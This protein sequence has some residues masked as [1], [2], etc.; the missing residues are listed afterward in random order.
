MRFV[1]RRLFAPATV[2]VAGLGVWL[3]FDGR[4]WHFRHVWSELAIGLFAGVLV[5]GAG[6]QRRAA[7]DAECAIAD[8][9]P[10]RARRT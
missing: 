5:I 9:N 6:L 2:L 4:R 10:D 1:D 3:V 8:G 7:I